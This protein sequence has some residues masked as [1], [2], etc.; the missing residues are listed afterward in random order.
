MSPTPATR[1]T[2]TLSP[3]AR[4]N[5]AL[6]LWADGWTLRDAHHDMVATFDY[7]AQDDELAAF[8]ADLVNAALTPAE[9]V[10]MCAAADCLN[11]A[12]LSTPTGAYCLQHDA[13]RYTAR[14]TVEDTLRQEG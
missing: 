6:P 9:P 13:V 4:D 3:E 2:I 14:W 12:D 10:R 7:Y 8:I 1:K 5:L 11:A